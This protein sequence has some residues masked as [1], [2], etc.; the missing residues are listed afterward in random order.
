MILVILAFFLQEK[1][2]G[3][4]IEQSFKDVYEKSCY[5]IVPPIW[6]YEISNTLGRLNILGVKMD[7]QKLCSFKD[8][9]FETI[10]LEDRVTE[11]VFS[12]MKKYQ[13]VSFYHTSYYAL[14]IHQKGTF[15][16]LDKRY[17]N[18]VKSEGFII[19]L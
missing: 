3:E 12:L 13:G 5:V 7:I 16:T 4:K 8:Y 1:G 6:F 10:E 2:A 14:A 15:L 9:L 19:L 17:F 11:I 18:Q